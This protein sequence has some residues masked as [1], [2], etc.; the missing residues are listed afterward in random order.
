MSFPREGLTL[1]IALS[2]VVL[3]CNTNPVPGPAES[4][5]PPAAG[6]EKARP[7]PPLGLPAG[8]Q[9]LVAKKPDALPAHVLCRL[10]TPPMDQPGGIAS[11]AVSPDGN[12]MAT[13]DRAGTN[14]VYVWDLKTGTLKWILQG[15]AQWIA[16][17]EFSAD[18]E[19]VL[20]S[21]QDDPFNNTWPEELVVWK[22]KAGEVAK[23]DQCADW[24]LARDGKA[25]ATGRPNPAPDDG[26]LVEK[27]RGFTVDVVDFPSHTRRRSIT[28]PT[29]P[30]YSVA[31]AP[32]GSTL[33]VGTANE[34]LLYDT[35]TGK[36]LPGIQGLK[37]RVH[38]LCFSHDGKTLASVS[39]DFFPRG[40]PHSVE[41]WGV[42]TG[43]RVGTLGIDKGWPFR[44]LEFVPGGKLLTQR[45]LGEYQ[46]WDLQTQQATRTFKAG[47]LTLFNDG[48]SLAHNDDPKD[49]W[50]GRVHFEDLA[51]GKTLPVQRSG[52]PLLP[53]KFSDD[54][55]VVFTRAEEEPGKG[56]LVQGWDVAT[57]KEIAEKRHRENIPKPPTL[58]EKPN[59][60]LGDGREIRYDWREHAFS[61]V[62]TRT[63]TELYHHPGSWT[64]SPDKKRL[65]VFEDTVARRRFRLIDLTTF[66]EVTSIPIAVSQSIHEDLFTPDG[67][68]FAV[69]EY[70]GPLR[71]YDATTGRLR[72]ERGPVVQVVF[73]P[74]ARLIAASNLTGTVDVFDLQE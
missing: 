51:T 24:S 36:E 10:G 32:D 60:D 14:Q 55:K 5:A 34:V 73:S 11:I 70:Q 12:W 23:Y 69:T 68:G 33:A 53:W 43:K 62:D 63:A 25:L 13:G 29:K 7:E 59:E 50:A 42:K 3:G 64:L 30:L 15:H 27:N 44:H 39:D 20:A 71:L 21:H 19:Y 54:G 16:R 1:L 58:M 22:V 18:G 61:I 2:A 47:V 57:G 40:V 8:H 66:Q 45:F 4:A 6:V 74:D 41:L 9:P 28:H 31:L 65:A 37:E 52:V 56:E 67:S 48:K 17:L 46:L 49:R 35:A 38:L 72:L 26:S